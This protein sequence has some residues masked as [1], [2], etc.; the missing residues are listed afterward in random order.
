MSRIAVL[1]AAL[2][3]T[4]IVP[5]ASAKSGGQGIGPRVPSGIGAQVK[6][7]KPAVNFTRMKLLKCHTYVRGHGD[8]VTVCN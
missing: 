7:D 6:P 3:A 2:A 8:H 1:I 5:A 4:A